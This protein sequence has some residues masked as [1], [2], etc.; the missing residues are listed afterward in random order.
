VKGYRSERA[1]NE[2]IFDR[3][4]LFTR[5]GNL[6]TH[7]RT[8]WSLGDGPEREE[9]EWATQLRARCAAGLKKDRVG[10]KNNPIGKFDSQQGPF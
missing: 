5:F 9:P 3:M 6:I 10:F 4:R 1:L 7:A 8:V 2:D